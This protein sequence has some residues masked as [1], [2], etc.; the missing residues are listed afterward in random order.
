[1]Q[2]HNR[3]SCSA[4]NGTQYTYSQID[5]CDE[6]NRSTNPDYLL[7]SDQCIVFDT[8]FAVIDI[9]TIRSGCI[10]H[11]DQTPSLTNKI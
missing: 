3:L 4:T 9:N 2:T 7:Y 1:M 6:E 8:I 5:G 10:Q 11:I